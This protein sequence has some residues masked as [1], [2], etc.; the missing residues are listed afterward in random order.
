MRQSRVAVL[1]IALA[2]GVVAPPALA[3]APVE[4]ATQP[5]VLEGLGARIDTHLS[6]LHDVDSFNGVVLVADGD[7]VLLLKGYG[8]ADHEKQT[9]WT[10]DTVSC[11]GSITKQF[12]AACIMRLVEQGKVSASDPLSKWFEGLPPDKAGITVHQLLT[13]TAG[14]TDILGE[15]EEPIGRDELMAKAWAE[16]LSAN[17]GEAYDYSNLGYS[18]LGAIIEKASGRPYEEFLRAELLRPAGLTETAYMLSPEAA[19]RVAIGYR[20]GKRWGMV[21]KNGWRED[22][23]GWHLRCNGGIQSTVSEMHAWVR[24]LQT[25]KVL[26]ADSVAEMWKP[27][28]PEPGGDTFYGYGWSVSEP[29]PGWKIVGHNGGN[30]YTFADCN[31][32]IETPSGA[33]GAGLM[34]I[35]MTNESR[36]SP[37]SEHIGRILMGDAP[38]APPTLARLADADL[39]RLEGKYEFGKTE[40]VTVMRA[41]GAVRLEGVG[42]RIGALLAGLTPEEIPGAERCAERV[43]AILTAAIKGELQPIADAYDG[44]VPIERLRAAYADRFEQMAPRIGKVQ[45]VKII[46]AALAEDPARRRILF[47]WVGDQG[48]SDL[49]GAVWEGD[50]LVGFNA[51]PIPTGVLA[52]P[53]GGGAFRAYDLRTGPGPEFRFETR[54]GATTLRLAPS[55]EGVTGSK[56]R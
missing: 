48:E 38:A 50:K 22:G 4:G 15:D 17:P 53:T 20:A 46:G 5:V 56:V 6:R 44:R 2:A 9:P 54:D 7:K 51:T 23:P 26:K 11:I 13:H 47:R 8:L 12:T 10:P 43:T 34:Y 25:A 33:P 45:G 21:Y 3:A 49:M 55:G 1:T 19:S 39:A 27:H 32:A 28:T 16:P 18:I 24:A 42:F 29:A 30:G 41:G 36:F 35:F 52:W 31:F 40:T 37:A 14:V